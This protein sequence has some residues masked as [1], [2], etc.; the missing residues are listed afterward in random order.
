[1]SMT[2]QEARLG[3]CS[4]SPGLLSSCS[5]GPNRW[6]GVFSAEVVGKDHIIDELRFTVANGRY[7]CEISANLRDAMH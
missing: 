4:F 6:S 3:W 7:E 1:M 2:H 5:P